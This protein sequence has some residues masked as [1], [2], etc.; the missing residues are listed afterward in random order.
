MK[1]IMYA[2]RILRFAHRYVNAPM[3]AAIAPEAPAMSTVER[4]SIPKCASAAIRPPT[5]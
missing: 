5:R 1:P 4:G 3:H 2:M